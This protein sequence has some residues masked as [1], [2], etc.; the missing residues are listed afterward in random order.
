MV[1]EEAVVEEEAVE[2][3]AA[4]P[5][6]LWLFFTSRK[7]RRFS[8]F[9]VHILIILSMVRVINFRRSRTYGLR[10]E[11]TDRSIEDEALNS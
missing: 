5:R 11:S 7:L 1:V 2:A 8:H 9:H 6:L 3:V 4:E 10:N